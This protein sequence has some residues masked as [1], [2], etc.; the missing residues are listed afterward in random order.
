MKHYPSQRKDK[1]IFNVYLTRCFLV[2]FC[3]YAKKESLE[4]HNQG[5]FLGFIYASGECTLLCTQFEENFELHI[6]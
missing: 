2:N 5:I 4:Q 6:V 3:H 1:Q